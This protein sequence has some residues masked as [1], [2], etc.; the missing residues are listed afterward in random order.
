MKFE[1]FKQ[2]ENTLDEDLRYLKT[3]PDEEEK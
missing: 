1:S 3:L 2:K